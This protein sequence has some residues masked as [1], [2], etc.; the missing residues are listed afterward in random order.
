MHILVVDDNRA[1]VES[2]VDIGC[3]L[4][5]T[6]TGAGSGA[7]ALECVRS[8]C[9]DFCLLDLR[10]PDMNGV[11]VHN[12]IVRM[13]EAAGSPLPGFA[14]VTG[15]ADPALL[16]RAG[17]FQV[18][19]LEKPISFARLLELVRAADPHSKPQPTES[20]ETRA[21]AVRPAPL[22]LNCEEA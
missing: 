1:F 21:P 7:A 22:Q 2:L 6:V 13:L 17:A 10:L 14:F 19:V 16:Q 4:G 3:L 18:P 9:F 15:F 8:E 5:I 11:Q 20:S 12:R